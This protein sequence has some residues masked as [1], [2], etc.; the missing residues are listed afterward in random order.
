MGDS[1][2]YEAPCLTNDQAALDS[3]PILNWVSENHKMDKS[4]DQTGIDKA[5]SETLRKI[6][7]NVVIFQKMEAMLKHLVAYGNMEGYMSDLEQVRT[8]RSSS[9]A[10]QPMGKLADAFVK[11]AYPRSARSEVTGPDD[12][13]GPWVSFCFEVE[14]AKEFRKERQKA[15]KAVVQ[16]RNKLI[17]QMLAHFDPGSLESCIQ[18]ASEL[19]RQKATVMPEY[20]LLGSM[21]N[22]LRSAHEELIRWL[23]S[24]GMSA[25]S[26]DQGGGP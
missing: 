23:D 16:E 20:R 13:A 25:A 14:S 1:I 21:M 10:R 17:H 11:S 4:P 7:R 12:L 8:Q 26:D 15:L 18:T 22:A 9:V 19:D 2:I 24:G 3:P 6:G 5:R